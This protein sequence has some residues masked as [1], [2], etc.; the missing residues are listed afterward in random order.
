MSPWH[1][2]LRTLC[3][4]AALAGLLAALGWTVGGGEGAREALVFALLAFLFAPRL[5]PLLLL[6]L[7]QV[8]PLATHEAPDL[9]HMVDLLAAR[10]GL[11]TA[12]VLYLVESP[13]VNAFTV[14][15]HPRPAICLT[16]GILGYL[17]PR[18]I[19]GVLAH[20][21]SHLK[22][23]DIRVMTLGDLF[24]RLTQLLSLFG[25]I[26]LVAYLPLLLLGGIRIHWLAFPLLLL[27]PGLAR[28]LLLTLSRTREFEADREAVLLSGD[29]EGLARALLQI[30]A[31]ERRVWPLPFFAPEGPEMFRSHP[32]T[33]ER[34]RRLLATPTAP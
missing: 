12:P 22:H 6:R 15:D 17:E 23:H 34:I 20:E 18:E 1:N 19:F 2:N 4:L 10:A 21:V 25:Q 32:P 31:A 26:L 28:I 33:A 27:A 29:A 5:S 30:E 9:Y 14:D 24:A 7:H 13:A 11:A 16:R 3:L 8:R